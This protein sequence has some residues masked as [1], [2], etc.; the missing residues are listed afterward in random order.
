MEQRYPKRSLL[1]PGQSLHLHALRGM[2]VVA[3]R[4]HIELVTAPLYMGEQIV[5]HTVMLHEGQAHSLTETGWITIR[6]RTTVELACVPGVATGGQRLGD[7]LAA[8][9]ATMR[10]F[11]FG[12]LGKS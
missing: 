4:G 12:S 6:A 9:R 10:R 11:T 7:L 1:Q 3:L 2:T 8:L 5:R